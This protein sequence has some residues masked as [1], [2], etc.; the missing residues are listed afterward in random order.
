MKDKTFVT[1]SAIFFLLFV[2]GIGAVTLNQPI[3]TMLRARNVAPSPLKSFGMIYPQIA[4]IG[5]PAIG[6]KPTDVKVSIY[7]RGV[8]GSILPNRNV[9]LTA[10]PSSTVSIKPGDVQVTNDIGQAQ[11]TVSSTFLGKV[12]L[13]AQETSTN[14]EIINIPTVEFVQ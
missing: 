6:Q 2:I 14:T 12:K 1:L 7:I 3:T 8:D 13:I 11:F 4:S 5:D 10:D 9:K